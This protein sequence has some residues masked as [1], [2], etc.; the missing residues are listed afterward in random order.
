MNTFSTHCQKLNWWCTPPTR[1]NITCDNTFHHAPSCFQMINVRML[2]IIRN[3]FWFKRCEHGRNMIK[4]A[5]ESF[6][7]FLT[8]V[9]KLNTIDLKLSNQ[10][11]TETVQ[12]L[13]SVVV[14][15]TTNQTC[16]NGCF[17]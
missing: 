5:K 12:L 14:R 2:T 13:G 9:H 7:V 1:H 16:W 10:R 4:S 6:H 11:A 8:Q 17:Y 15:Q 3:V